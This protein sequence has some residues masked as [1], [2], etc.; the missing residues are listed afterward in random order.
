M[1]HKIFIIEDDESILYGL[2]EKFTS[3]GYEVEISS[4][5]EDIEELLSRVKKIQ[6][7]YVI[8]DLLLPKHDGLEVLKRL[9]NDSE[10]ADTQVLI[11]TDLSDEDSKSRSI[12]LGAN[13]YFL[14][15][16]MDIYEFADKVESIIS[17]KRVNDDDENDLVME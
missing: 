2:Q 1:A 11:F 5:D 17:E 12:G 4:A 14:K 13:Y 16:E 9:R 8:L 3:D 15:S 7:N 10:L 6:P